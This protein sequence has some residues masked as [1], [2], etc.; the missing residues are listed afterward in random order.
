MAPL[1][2][3]RVTTTVSFSIISRAF[4]AELTDGAAGHGGEDLQGG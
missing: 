2:R 3:P 4:A 1:L